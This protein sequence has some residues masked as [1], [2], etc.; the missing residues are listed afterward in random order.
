MIIRSLDSILE[1]QIK[2]CEEALIKN[3]HLEI[4]ILSNRLVNLY[5][6]EINQINYLS[7]Y[8]SYNNFGRG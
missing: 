8:E 5:L 6:G 1:N 7:Q 4:N 3:D 2:E